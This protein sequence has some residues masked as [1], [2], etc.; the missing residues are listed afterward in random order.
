MK[1]NQKG[2][3]TVETVLVVIIAALIGAVGFMVYKNQ[4]KSTNTVTVKP[5]TTQSGTKPAMDSTS[6]VKYLKISEE[7]IKFKLTSNISDAYYYK[8]SNGYIYLSVHKLDSTKGA[9]GCVAHD[10]NGIGQGLVAL[11]VGYVGGDT[12]SPAGGTWT[13]ADLDKTNLVNIGTKYYGFQKGNGPCYDPDNPDVANQVPPLIQE[14]LQ[15]QSTI[16]KL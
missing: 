4:N 6:T 10:V 7:G 2:F 8:S 11:N 13:Q 14:L 9:E 5:K 15:Q 16:T 3:S 1:T 12:G